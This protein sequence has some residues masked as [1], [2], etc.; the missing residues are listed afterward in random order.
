MAEDT[1]R[2]A[3][4][5]KDHAMALLRAQPAEVWVASASADGAPHLV[6][7]SL[8]WD[9]RQVILSVESRS[10]TARNVTST[11]RTRLALG[12][13]GDVVLIDAVLA[14]QVGVTEAAAELAEAYAGQ[15]D[16]DPRQE[17]SSGAGYIYLCVAPERI[18]VW[19]SLAEHSGRTI[20]RAG[21]WLA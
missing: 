14:A 13:T 11:Q 4:E 10:L 12:T 15:A 7:L 16:W 5:R 17:E 9:E 8:V 19:R 20:M 2:T 3:Q 18:Q 6:P 21:Q 1:V